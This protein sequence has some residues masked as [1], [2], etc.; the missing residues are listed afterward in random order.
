MSP[1]LSRPP[2]DFS[3]RF[4]FGRRPP[5]IVASTEEQPFKLPWPEEQSWPHILKV[6]EKALART[7]DEQCTHSAGTTKKFRPPRE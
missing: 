1:T 2:K 7:E 5:P 4:T 6:N 3:E